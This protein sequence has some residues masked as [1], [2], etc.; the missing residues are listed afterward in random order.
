LTPDP[1]HG[2]QLTAHHR[3]AI[4]RL[5]ASLE[6]DRSILA[7]L[8][9]GSLAHGYARP[10][11]DIDVLLLVS[12]EDMR[13]YRGERRLTW[14]DRSYC[15]WDG[16][17]VDAKYVDVE[18]LQRVAAR[19]S[20]PARYAFQG[21]RILS[22]RVDG[23]QE[24]LVDATRYPLEGRQQRVERFAAQMLAWRWYH[25]EAIRQANPYLGSLA[26]QKV[27][28]FACRIV[29]A[30]NER[31]Y[32]YHKWLLREVG[33][34]PDRPPTLLEDIDGLLREPDQD[35][36]VRFVSDVLEHFAIDE[37]ETNATWPDLF[38]RDTEQAWLEGEPAVDDL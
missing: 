27:I 33:R 4:E 18:F 30:R 34:A 1:L 13:R 12:P 16:G 3:A 26:R 24:L 28:L 19:G 37:A 23:L 6:P 15:D 20:E 29:L 11:S 36:V 5:R 22:S 9:A 21:A 38:M 32:P 8:L 10:D 25:S 35:R 17:Y 2:L 14:A 7:L 31:L